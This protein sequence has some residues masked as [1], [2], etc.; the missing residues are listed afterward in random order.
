MA[1]RGESKNK[2]NGVKLPIVIVSVI[3]LV[4]FLVWMGI[5]ALGPDTPAGPTKSGVVFD[6]WMD[7]I[8]KDS[9]GDVSKLSPEDLNKLQASSYGHA[10]QALSHYAKD[11]GY[12]K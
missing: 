8:A 1:V 9:G 4:A 6:S 7:K 10:E 12:A 2:G 11:H 3:A 5:R